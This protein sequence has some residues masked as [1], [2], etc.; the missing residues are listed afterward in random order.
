MLKNIVESQSYETQTV[1][2][3]ILE[4]FFEK[5]LKLTDYF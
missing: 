5:N 1:I 4:T 2:P 3:N